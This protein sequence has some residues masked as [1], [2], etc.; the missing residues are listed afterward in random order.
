[1]SPPQH[2]SPPW[3]FTTDAMV[4]D[5]TPT[6]PQTATIDLRQRPPRRSNTHTTRTRPEPEN[7]TRSDTEKKNITPK[8]SE[9]MTQPELEEKRKTL[10]PV[11]IEHDQTHTHYKRRKTS[12]TE[13][14]KEK[15]RPSEKNR[16]PAPPDG[17][18]KHNT[19]EKKRTQGR[20]R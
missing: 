13:N 19:I 16:T 2:I 4:N 9:N 11:K 8:R 12:K 6:R 10:D 14:E 15:Q 20:K 1:M 18:E 3:L 17:N 7:D 5:R